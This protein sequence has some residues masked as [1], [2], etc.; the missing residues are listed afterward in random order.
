MERTLLR[1]LCAL[2]RRLLPYAVVPPANVRGHWKHR[3]SFGPDKKH[4]TAS[5]TPSGTPTPQRHLRKRGRLVLGATPALLPRFPG[6][7][8]HG[9]GGGC[10]PRATPAAAAANSR[11]RPLSPRRDKA[12]PEREGCRH[13]RA[14][15]DGDGTRV[16][17]PSTLDGQPPSRSNH[18][19]SSS[20]S[21]RTSMT[22]AY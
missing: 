4:T 8:H 10:I 11:R 22:T 13:L 21:S 17:A 1:G 16:D 5:D 14:T 18:S 20:S 7:R 2:P 12:P 6:G 15:A 3:Q 19:S 9:Y